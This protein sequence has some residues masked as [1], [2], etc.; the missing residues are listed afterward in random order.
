M[1]TVKNEQQFAKL[2]FVIGGL[3][4]NLVRVKNNPNR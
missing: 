1:T 4:M 3:K 2:I